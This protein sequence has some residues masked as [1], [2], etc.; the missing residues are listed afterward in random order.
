M[1]R[2][3]AKEALEKR[4]LFEPPPDDL[5]D[6]DVSEIYLGEEHQIIVK[7]GFHE[8]RLV[9]FFI[10]WM[11]RDRD[12]EWSE[13]YSVCTK[14]GHLHE[15]PTGHHR[16]N[17]RVDLQPLRSQVDVQESYDK[18]YERVHSRYIYATGGG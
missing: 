6:I 16:P 2:R 12:G 11:A 10:A 7:L 15:H 14:H 5:C 13:R 9:L 17:D 1:A 4:E 18:A 3:A 8:G